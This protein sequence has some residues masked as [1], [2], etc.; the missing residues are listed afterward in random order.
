M[1]MQ[2][3]QIL[4]VEN[5][6]QACEIIAEQT[7]R[8]LGYRVVVVDSAAAAFKE[9]SHLAPDMI[10]T[11]LS[12]P[13]ISGKD[14]LVALA[15]QNISVPVVII[16]TKGHESDALQAF[17]LGAVNFLN[18]PI[19]EAE[20]VK[21]VEDTLNQ[22][23][24]H[25]QMKS[26]S[27]QL[28]QSKEALEH[29]IH[30]F[31]EIFSIARLLPTT[32]EQNI[33]EKV[34]HAGLSISEAEV[35][36]LLVLERNN[37][38]YFL[39]AGLNLSQG[40]QSKLNTPY[41][42]GLSSLVPVSGQAIS[43]HGEALNRFNLEMQVESVLAVPIKRSDA[44]T[45]IMVVARKMPLPFTHDQQSLLET[46]AGYASVLFENSILIQDLERRLALS[47]QSNIAAT[48]DSD[49]K[50]D[51]LH[52]LSRELQR[53]IN[54]TIVNLDVLSKQIRRLFNPKQAGVIDAIRTETSVLQELADSISRMEKVRVSKTLELVDLNE[55]VRDIV[56]RS[57]D[58]AK[59]CEL[60][61][62]LVLPSQPARVMV[63]SS[64]ITRVIEGMVSNA[65]KYSPP[66]SQILLLVEVSSESSRLTVRNQGKGVGENLAEWVFDK[67]ADLH[68][69]EAG[70][71]GG[72]GIG[73]PMMKEIITA[74]RGEISVEGHQGKGFTI[75]FAIPNKL[76]HPYQV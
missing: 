69:D 72:I 31:T 39:R 35:A 2:R 51:L 34:T 38:K 13:E 17:R 8:P 25:N 43:M 67:Q 71:F 50:D 26:T 33:Y 48:I 4:L 59:A 68:E 44:V 32:P 76:T 52:Q 19:R 7:L 20:V 22:V 23:R 55:L 15:S 9:I 60:S 74:H 11:N 62:K 45:G 14:L 66:K 54:Q 12:L 56:I 75:S 21:V 40:M 10:I 29:R 36:W 16:T 47:Q 73:L 46:I 27:Q 3:E 28:A 64:H 30:S 5:D 70:R 6:P 42:D 24:W 53:P 61:F 41:E 63:Y 37:G 58:M 49:L 57:Q 65:L 18:S 1:E